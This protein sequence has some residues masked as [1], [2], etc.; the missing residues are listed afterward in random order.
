MPRPPYATVREG[1]AAPDFTLPSDRGDAVTL[2]ALR[3]RRVVLYFYPKDGSV[4]CTVQAGDFRD[5][6]RRL[7][8]AGVAVL[9]VSPDSVR[10]HV[11]FREALRLTFPL[12]ADTDQTVAR[13]YGLWHEKLFFGRKY[14]GMMRTTFVI[15]PDGR[16]E[17]LWEH[18]EHQGHAAE[19][20][21]Y[22]GEAERPRTS[23]AARKK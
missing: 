12:L 21:A 20:E 8:R 15:G 18:V 23:R 5:R 14:M 4:G 9:G 6:V 1:D 16:V 2:S 3:G 17:R 11:R 10:K 7:A 22:L 13:A 19:V